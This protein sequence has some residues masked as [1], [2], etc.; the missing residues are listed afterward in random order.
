MIK[1]QSLDRPASL[2][3]DCRGS[4]SSGIDFFTRGDLGNQKGSVVGGTLFP[5][6]E[7]TAN[8]FSTEKLAF[9]M[10]KFL[11]EF[12]NDYSLWRSLM[13]PRVPTG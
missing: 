12:Q 6:W 13:M 11:K 8:I 7:K 2:R 10:E 5:Q 1:F 9:V 4:F 3:C